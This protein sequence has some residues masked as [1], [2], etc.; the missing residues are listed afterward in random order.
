[1]LQ[2]GNPVATVCSS[3]LLAT[4]ILTTG[5]APCD[6]RKLIG[7]CIKARNP[8]PIKGHRQ[9]A[10]TISFAADISYSHFWTPS[11]ILS[12]GVLSLGFLTWGFVEDFCCAGFCRGL[13]PNLI[14][15]SG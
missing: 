14:W 7:L 1:M 2:M 6:V 4:A 9:P 8:V 11:G 13:D 3:V 10:N 5:G 12:C 15:H